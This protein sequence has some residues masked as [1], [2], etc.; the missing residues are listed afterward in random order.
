MA[1]NLKAVP[2]HMRALLTGLFPLLSILLGGCAALTT[3]RPESSA[4]I[5]VPATWLESGKGSNGR[6]STGW[7]GEFHDPRMK[8]IVR[9][10]VANNNNLKATAYRLR[11]ARE[12]TIGAHAARLPSVNANG[13]YS[14]SRSG[15][16]SASG[17]TSE[18]YSL[19]LNASWEPDLWGRLRDL[20]EA[21]FASYEAAV[22][23]FR[24]ARLSLAVNSAKA[25]ARVCVA[26]SGSCG[27]SRA[28]S[29]RRRD[30]PHAPR[31]PV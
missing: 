23:A 28:I 6:I 14:R 11:A 21:S 26:G 13:G 12:G 19:S 16:G 20:D 27:W 1:G 31:R 8:Q 30:A 25:W 10:A 22:A 15:N 2:D 17:V 4:R 5:D 7:L 29:P 24:S 3:S 9:E 18:S